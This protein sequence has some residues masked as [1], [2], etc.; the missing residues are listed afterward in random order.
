MNIQEYSNILRQYRLYRLPRV[1]GTPEQVPVYKYGDYFNLVSRHNGKAP[2]FISRC[3]Y[4]FEG[5]VATIP[6]MVKQGKVFHDLDDD[7]NVNNAYNDY[8]K[9]NKLFESENLKF[10]RKCSG[11]KGYHVSL[12]TAYETYN[13]FEALMLKNYT[14]LQYFKN[15]LKLSTVDLHSRVTVAMERAPFTVHSVVDGE[16]RYCV[17]IPPDMAT[18]K[19]DIVDLVYN[20]VN[21]V[22]YTSGELMLSLDQIINYFELDICSPYDEG[23][24]YETTKVC[25]PTSDLVEYLTFLIPQKC[26]VNELFRKNPTHDA[27]V[28][29]IVWLR[30]L[31]FNVS[32]ATALVDRVANEV[33]W[34]DV[35]N[36]MMRHYQVRNV[37]NKN[38]KISRCDNLKRLGVCIGQEECKWMEVQ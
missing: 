4:Y 25:T 24:D 5:G 33:P 28:R 9:L 22:N 20:P 2:I 36:T 19:M 30:Y 17:P 23:K 32:D 10:V 37:I 12:I 11:G 6:K 29:F 15:K 3:I 35:E 14:I 13:D 7:D 21:Y 34:R 16:T 31:E 38:Y 26:V 8:L 1:V 27:R 18:S